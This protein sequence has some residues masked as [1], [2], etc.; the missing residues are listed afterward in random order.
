MATTRG[1]VGKTANLARD[2]DILDARE[3]AA[4]LA[5][6]DDKI[7]RDLAAAGELPGMR[8]GSGSQWVFS[9]AAV[10][11]WLAGPGIPDGEILDVKQLAEKL[12]ISQQLV[13]R[14]AGE[15]GTP[16]RFPGR[17]VGNK[18]L[19]ALE[20]VRAAIRTPW[21]PQPSADSAAPG[22]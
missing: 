14:T 19:F 9:W 8:V 6:K 2:P 13:R 4:R 1:K 3:L 21:Q 11:A 15:P 17:K 16:D 12:D 22:T 7:I 10:Y 5:I 20:A 18:W